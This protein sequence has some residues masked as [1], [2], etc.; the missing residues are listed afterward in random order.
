[1]NRNRKMNLNRNAVVMRHLCDNPTYSDNCEVVNDE[2]LGWRFANGFQ[3][4]LTKEQMRHF[5]PESKLNLY[6]KDYGTRL[7]NRMD[8]PH[9]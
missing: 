4:P 6:E 1:M 7:K 3:M 8:R 5:N 9:V 2:R